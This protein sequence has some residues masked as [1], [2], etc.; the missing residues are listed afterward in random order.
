M[1][2]TAILERKLLSQ[3][4]LHIYEVYHDTVECLTAAL[5]ARDQ[6]TRGHSSRVADMVVLMAQGFKL[7]AAELETI[8]IA[9]HLHDIGK[10]AIPDAILFKTGLLT[11][12]ERTVIEQHPVI[13]SKILCSSRH[14]HDV[15]MLVLHH[16]ER[17]DGRG[18][19]AKLQGTAIPLGSR[20]I[21]I[22]DA[23]EAMLSDRPY[24][25]ALTTEQCREQLLAGRDGQFDAMLVGIALDIFFSGLQA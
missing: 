2:K 12:E 17:W 9:A 23:I 14:L 7:T 20:I 22:C 15:A 19:P 10:I 5:D 25:K 6:Y 24:R 4:S 1:K 13:G 16:H 21:A 11:A 8:H 18:Y 3:D